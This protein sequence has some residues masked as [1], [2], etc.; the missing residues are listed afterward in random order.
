MI[1][2]FPKGE[3]V[4]AGFVLPKEII[5]VVR[6]HAFKAA[7]NMMSK[8]SDDVDQKKLLRITWK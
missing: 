5:A 3:T 2:G 4:Q 8:S 6:P 7:D 1:Q